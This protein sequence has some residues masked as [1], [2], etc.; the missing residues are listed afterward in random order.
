[1]IKDSDLLKA[2][3]ALRLAKRALREAERRYDRE[4]GVDA[5][6]F[7]SRIRLAEAKV[8][9]ARAALHKVEPGSTE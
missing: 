7:I 6:P 5:K 1:M 9:A 4:C 2:R 8:Q 3:E